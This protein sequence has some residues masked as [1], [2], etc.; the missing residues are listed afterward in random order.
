MFHQATPIP[1]AERMRPKQLEDLV[2][3]RHLLAAQQ[4]LF[5]AVKNKQAHSM[6]LWGPPGVRKNKLGSFA[7]RCFSNALYVIKRY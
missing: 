2:G 5:K 3:Q 4:P 7:S 6:L 1:L